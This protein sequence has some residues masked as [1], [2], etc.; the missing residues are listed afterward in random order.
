MCFGEQVIPH[1][2][3]KEPR[4]AVAQASTEVTLSL[5]TAGQD[6]ACGQAGQT[7]L[8]WVQPQHLLETQVRGQGGGQWP[9]VLRRRLG[10]EHALH[11]CGLPLP[12]RA[13]GRRSCHPALPAS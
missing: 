10:H 8:R 6:I 1:F 11:R 13:F 3:A 9:T 4:M 7:R 5:H 12:V 2:A